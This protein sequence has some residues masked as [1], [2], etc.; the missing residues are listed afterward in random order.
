V[1]FSGLLDA[2]DND[3]DISGATTEPELICKCQSSYRIA[4]MKMVLTRYPS[5]YVRYLLAGH[6]VG[7]PHSVSGAFELSLCCRLHS[8][9]FASRLPYW[10]STL[11]SKSACI[12]NQGYNGRPKWH[13]CKTNQIIS[14]AHGR[15][16]ISQ[17]YEDRNQFARKSVRL[18]NA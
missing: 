4:L 5:E 7:P 1:L 3:R 10:P 14:R 2:V 9:L 6:E 11:I 8:I 13:A 15:T 18:L 12:S 16:D 17:A